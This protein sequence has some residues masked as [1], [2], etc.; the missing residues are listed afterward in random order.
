MEFCEFETTLV[1]KSSSRT[2]RATQRN[3]VLFRQLLRC[4]ALLIIVF[5]R[6]QSGGPFYNS[7]GQAFF[8]LSFCPLIAIE[9]FAPFSRPCGQTVGQTVT[10]TASHQSGALK[11]SVFTHK[12]LPKILHPFLR[13]SSQKQVTEPRGANL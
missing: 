8:V 12:V 9:T 1:Y 5:L 13:S 2:A 11:A 10:C 3:P 7:W 6:R 4:R